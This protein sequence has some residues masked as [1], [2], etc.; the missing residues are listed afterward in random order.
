M[1]GKAIAYGYDEH[2]EKH[3]GVVSQGGNL[4]VP[5]DYDYLILTENNLMIAGLEHKYGVL[6]MEGSIKIPFDYDY[7]EEPIYQG[8]AI[9]KLRGKVGQ[10]DISGNVVIPFE[11]DEI[12]YFD[13]GFSSA[14]KNG[15]YG[16]INEK[17]ETVVPFEYIDTDV[18]SSHEFEVITKVVGFGWKKTKNYKIIDIDKEHAEPAKDNKNKILIEKIREEE[19]YLAKVTGRIKFGVFIK[20]PDLGDALIP[21]KYLKQVGKSIN[22]Y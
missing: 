18:K 9:A 21:A 7:I 5:F 6:T 15:K 4:I 1:D 19:I 20:I 11:F 8:K 2:H 16:I 13:H 10:I 17:G 3:Y 14:K 22:S 12:K